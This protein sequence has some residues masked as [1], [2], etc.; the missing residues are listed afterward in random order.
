MGR[1]LL[2][3]LKLK[4]VNIGRASM[5]K[6]GQ[7]YR[8]REPRNINVIASL[9]NLANDF[10]GIIERVWVAGSNVSYSFVTLRRAVSTIFTSRTTVATMQF[11]YSG[12]W[13][14]CGSISKLD[15]W[16]MS[17]DLVPVL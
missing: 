12:L 15:C 4:W 7:P 11:I 3:C 16:F 10:S 5:D 13:Q 8:S 9:K 14:L 1:D 6:Y 2:S 17:N